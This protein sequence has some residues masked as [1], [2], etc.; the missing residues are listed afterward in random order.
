MP[1]VIGIGEFTVESNRIGLYAQYM[2]KG[3]F[4]TGKNTCNSS[5]VD[6]LGVQLVPAT[7]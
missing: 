6:I 2:R 3:A 5:P 7:G 1:R 4:T